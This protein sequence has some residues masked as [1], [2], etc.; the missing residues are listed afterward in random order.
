MPYRLTHMLLASGLTAA[1]LVAGTSA[2]QW[3][4]GDRRPAV[5]SAMRTGVV[6]AAVLIPVQ[7]FVGDQHGLNT[8]HHQPAKIAAM[9]DRFKSSI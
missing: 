1:F 9:E 8:L 3:W 5:L 4:R 7:M 6:M 2:L